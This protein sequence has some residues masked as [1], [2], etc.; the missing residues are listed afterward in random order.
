MLWYSVNIEEGEVTVKNS[1]NITGLEF[2][3]TVQESCTTDRTN[4]VKPLTTLDPQAIST[5]KLPLKD[6]LYVIHLSRIDLVTGT[7]IEVAEV[8]F[9]YFEMLLQS[10]IK[11]TEHFLCGCTC[12]ECDDCNQDEKTTLS[13]LLKS[14][15][16]YTIMYK[17]Y[18]RFYDAVFKCLNC[19]IIDVTSCVIINEKVLGKTENK[20]LLEKIISSL[21]LAIYFGEYYSSTDKEAVDRKF[22]FDKIIKCIKHN[23]TDI[24]CIKNNIEQNMGIFSISFGAYVNQPPSVV[25]DYNAG[26]QGNRTTLTL[27]VGMFTNLTTPPYADPENDPAQAIRIDSLATNGAVITLNNVAVTVGQVVLISDIAASKLKISGPDQNALA[28]SSFTFSVRD[29]GS[30]QFTS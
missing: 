22:N 29:T 12:K 30:M 21:Y 1:D 27:T 23:D 14:F 19:S 24:D 9:P 11:D 16:Y 7:T 2:T 15:S 20:E 4:L 13:I 25:G 28:N 10:V 18:S 8:P 6:G 3:V 17:Y 5:F 26:T